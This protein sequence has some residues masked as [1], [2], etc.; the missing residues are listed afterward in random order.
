MEGTSVLSFILFHPMS[1]PSNSP[2]TKKHK[3]YKITSCHSPL[4]YVGCTARSLEKRHYEHVKE[5][6]AHQAGRRKNVCMS[7]LVVFKGD[8][9]IELLEE[10]DEGDDHRVR[11]KE[12]VLQTPNTANTKIPTYTCRDWQLLTPNGQRYLR[13]QARKVTCE[14]CGCTVMHKNIQRHYQT[15]KCMAVRAKNNALSHQTDTAGVEAVEPAQE[16]VCQASVQ[17]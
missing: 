10:V 1:S 8:S 11:E 3:I 14:H 2:P 13:N 7:S 9:H 15:K 4:C 12:W 6:V 17:Q 16:G 5:C